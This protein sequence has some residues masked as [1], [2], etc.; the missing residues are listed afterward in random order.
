MLPSEQKP[1]SSRIR[2]FFGFLL[3]RFVP[4]ILI[5][6]ISWSGYRVAAS[7]AQQVGNIS[8]VN[9]RSAAYVQTATAISATV[10]TYTPTNTEI[11]TNTPIPTNTHTPLPTD[12]PLPT[13]TRLP[14][15]ATFTSVPPSATVTSPPSPTPL[16]PTATFTLTP[17]PAAVAQVFATNTPRATG[18]AFVTNTPLGEVATATPTLTPTTLLTATTLPTDTAVPTATFT[19]APVTE[20][21]APLPTLLLPRNPDESVAQT[22]PTAVPP[23]DRQGYD[24]M[25]II[26]LGGDDEVT[27]DL[28]RTDTMIIVSINRTTNTVSMINLPRDLYVYVPTGG[29]VMARLNV[30]YGIGDSMGWTGG[31]FGLLRQTIFYNFGI[32][33]HYYARVDF[34]GFEEIIDTLGGI[35]VAVDCTYEDWYPVEDFDITRPLEE[36]YEL[37]TLP[38][39][40]YTLNGFD[41]LWYAR[42]RRNTDDFDRGRRQ[43]QV[44]RAVWRRARSTGQL[45]NLP[46]LWGQ[47]TEVVDT[48]LRLEDVIGLLPLGLTMDFNA[49]ETFTIGRAHTTP[50]NVDGASVRLPV[51]ENL[52]PY[53]QDFYLP[54][55]E[56]QIRVEAAT[57]IVRNGTSNAQWDWVAAG[58][59][60]EEGFNA[61]AG[62]DADRLD[63]TETMLID[64]TGQEKGSSL[65]WVASV[66][67]VRREN[68]IIDPNPSREYDFEVILGAN[69][70][71]CSDYNVLPADE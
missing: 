13:S 11:P 63:Y 58:R 48:N 56:S 33:V 2:R 22:V 46:T 25:N 23:L 4:L 40:Y 32:N 28:G 64:Y 39:G 41:A 9:G 6:G 38:V 54:P 66:L 27:E 35:D 5:I 30:V 70:D 17:S 1:K 51:Y 71:S 21:P 31:G 53:L 45:A 55:T 19:L 61:V 68:I 44:L 34:T 47:L 42:I 10:V 20:T 26:L 60:G 24:L 29:T 59:L 37:R 50:M 14:P 15:T 67:N 49:V 12:T 57:I 3:F 52:R 7:V 8:Q 65:E 69:Y 62:G 16:P 43:Q 36:N 18:A